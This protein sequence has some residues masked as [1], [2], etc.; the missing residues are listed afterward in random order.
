MHAFVQLHFSQRLIPTTPILLLQQLVS[1]QGNN[2]N[3]NFIF[4]EFSC[5]SIYIIEAV[6]ELHFCL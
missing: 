3:V 4:T 1:V 5:K 2:V 6:I